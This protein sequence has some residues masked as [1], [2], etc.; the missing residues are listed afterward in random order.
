M[1]CMVEKRMEYRILIG[2]RMEEVIGRPRL[3]E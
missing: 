3:D 1:A 2:K